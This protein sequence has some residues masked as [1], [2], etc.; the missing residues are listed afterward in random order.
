MYCIGDSTKKMDLTTDC[1]EDVLLPS[2]SPI[3]LCCN[4]EEHIDSSDYQP[5]VTCIRNPFWFNSN[6][7]YLTG[8][9]CMV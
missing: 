2:P 4:W 7:A 1:G 5:P 3:M 6:I 8:M 9:K